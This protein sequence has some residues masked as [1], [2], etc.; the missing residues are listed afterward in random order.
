MAPELQDRTRRTRPRS[1]TAAAI[2][3]SLDIYYRDAARTERMDRLNAAF[4]PKGGLAFDIG[5]HV[6]DRTASFRRLGARVVALEPQPR[7]FRALRL[8]HGKAPDVMLCPEA[9][10]A[11][12]GEIDMHVNAQN[13]T[14]S[15]ASPELIA[16]AQ[17]A[18]GWEGQVWDTTIRVPATTLDHLIAQH[19]TPD[20]I[21]IDVE[22]H[23]L[24]VL[25]GLTIPVAALSFEFTTIQRDIAQACIDHL[26]AL[27]PY[28]FNLSLGE[29]HT[30]RTQDWTT[31]AQ[32]KAI[33]TNLPHAANSGDIYARLL[34]RVSV[35]T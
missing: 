18:P 2:G 24:E 3:R 20:F 17:S 15:T 29:D 22:G 32:L 35:L 16:A 14:V 12:P 33:L 34:W 9:A 1:G 26:S 4:V 23:E 27:G 28:E 19:G 30:L 10:G 7:I 5:A 25:K 21:K 6:G 31:A 13:P 8:I 11:Q